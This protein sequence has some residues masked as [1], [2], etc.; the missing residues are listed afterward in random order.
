MEMY[1][2]YFDTAS[3]GSGYRTCLDISR[4]GAKF[5]TLFVP[6]ELVV[7]KTDKAQLRTA[8]PMNY[9]KKR[10]RDVILRRARLAKRYG[11]KFPRKVTLEVI[12]QLGIG[13]TRDEAFVAPVATV[14]PVDVCERE[15]QKL[16]EKSRSAKKYEARK[17]VRVA[18][19]A[20]VRGQLG[21]AF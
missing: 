3:L 19:A 16:I 13:G 2:L 12:R 4:P 11:M 18:P 9:M 15:D 17:I 8:K 5:A 21:F 14:V 7:V 20:P 6:A 1:R 10:V